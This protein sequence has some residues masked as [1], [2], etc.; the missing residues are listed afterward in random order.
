MYL[1]FDTETT[2]LPRDY[3]A[4]ITDL[5]NWPRLVQ[6]AWLL[7]NSEDKLFTSCNVII[8]PEGFT[9]PEEVAKL[10]GITQERALE[11]GKKLADVLKDFA[12][13]LD[14]CSHLVAH[15][16][17]FDEKIVGAE[18]L[19]LKWPSELPKRTKICTMNSSVKFCALP[20]KFGYK[21]PKLEELHQKLFGTDFSDQHNAASDIQ[22]TARCFFELKR[23]KVIP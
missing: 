20:G 8:K 23:L 5:E 1:F 16:M 14:K 15:N 10:H 4:P 19:R 7:Y 17:A 6:L 21:W 3:K 12:M 11:E 13:A 2:G 22:A 9:I 18:Y